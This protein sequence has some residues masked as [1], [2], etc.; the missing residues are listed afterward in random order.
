MRW[1]GGRGVEG[2]VGRGGGEGPFRFASRTRREDE[3][4]GRI[5]SRRPPKCAFQNHRDVQNRRSGGTKA[6]RCVVKLLLEE[7]S[8]RKEDRVSF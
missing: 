3:A 4:E 6:R 5:E 7:E 1:D 8:R 2:R